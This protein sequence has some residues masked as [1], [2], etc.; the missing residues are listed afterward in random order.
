MAHALDV[1]DV[2]FT[3]PARRKHPRLRALAGVSLKLEP[4]QTLA[5]LGPNGSGKSTLMKIICGLISADTGTVSVFG[6]RDPQRIRALLGVVFQHVALDR[7]MTVEENLRDQARLY[8]IGGSTARD[9]I[10]RELGAAGLSDRRDAPVKTLS[11]GMR[12]R[13]DL[14]RA[15]LHHPRLLLLDEPT[16]GLDPVAR[17]SFLD[18]IERRRDEHDLTIVM[19]THLI[20]EADRQDRV[21]LL[22]H[23]SIIADDRP[24]AL[25]HQIGERVITVMDSGY[26]PPASAN[27]TWERTQTGWS[28]CISEDDDTASDLTAALAAKGV[29]FSF[30]PPTLANVFERLTGASLDERADTEEPVS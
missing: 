17:A 27:G 3:Y 2:Y 12:R 6:E 20:D 25:R 22:H 29:S 16:V 30:A 4:G 8:G 21:V 26:R 1:Q 24:V 13:V 11:G 23:G 7:H 28:L 15:L 14:C 9:L 10:D 19:S 5:M 18:E